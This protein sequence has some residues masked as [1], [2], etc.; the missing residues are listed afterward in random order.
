MAEARFRIELWPSAQRELDA[1]RAFEKRKLADAMKSQLSYEPLVVTRNRKPL[2][3][4]AAPFEFELP[5]WELKVGEYR[6]FY[7]VS[8]ENVNVRSIRL[9]PPGKTTAE[10]LQ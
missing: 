2:P 5:L 7:D 6:V 1:L 4:I 10:I 9:K 3:N 8:K